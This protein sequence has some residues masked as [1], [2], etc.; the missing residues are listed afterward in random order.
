MPKQKDGLNTSLPLNTIQQGDCIAVMNSLPEGSVDLI[1]ADPPYNMQLGGELTRPDN[2]K[3][4]A[5]TDEWDQFD[6]YK[7]YDDFTREWLKAAK[8]ILKPN[9]AIWVIGSY[10]NIFRVGSELQN[11]GYWIQNDVQWI[12]NNPMPNMRGTR[13]ANATETLIWATPNAG[14]KNTFNYEVLKAANG[15]RQM[16]NDWY[17]PICSGGERLKDED[18][19][20]VHT[21]QKPEALLHRII[22]A[23]SKAGDVILDPFFG[24]GTTG[25]VAKK[26]GRNFIGIEREDAYI[27]AA[28]K[29]I[30]AIEGVDKELL[31]YTAKR[32]MPKVP[33]SALVETNMISPN[34]V[35]QD[36]SGKYRAIV[37]ADGLIQALSDSNVSN[38]LRDTNPKAAS[39]HRVGAEFRGQKSCN[40]WDMWHVVMPDGSTVSI[41]ALRNDFRTQM[42]G[43]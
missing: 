15:D 1:F 9:G 32:D 13:L 12:K 10:H 16:R 3:V 11:Q 6:S 41:D 2:S 14:S 29:R 4:D 25:A 35:L 21:T 34:S 27:A 38:P 17:F 24:S 19:N 33:F 37:R 36:S 42:A 31:E 18:G 7:L 23:T 39:I 40:G 8:R 30:D 20:K 5:V 43:N 26:L 28:E 22:I